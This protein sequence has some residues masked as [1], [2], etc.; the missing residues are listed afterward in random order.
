MPNIK[1][2]NTLKSNFQNDSIYALLDTVAWKNSINHSNTTELSIQG[3]GYQFKKKLFIGEGVATTF[4]LN[5]INKY[6]E[7]YH[8]HIYSGKGIQFEK[9]N[10]ITN[11]VF[12]A[13]PE[14]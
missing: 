3:V 8:V 6:D 14:R 4:W 13:H 10:Y 5:Q 7:Y 11:E 12:H 2:W 9:S 1:D